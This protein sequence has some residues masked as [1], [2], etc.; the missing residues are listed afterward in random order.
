M[1]SSPRHLEARSATHR[2]PKIAK[3]VSLTRIV[4]KSGASER[5]ILEFLVVCSSKC[6][7]RPTLPCCASSTAL[8]DMRELRLPFASRTG[9]RPRAVLF[10]RPSRVFSPGEVLTRFLT[11]VFP[12][13]VPA[14]VP[15]TRSSMTMP[16]CGGG[17]TP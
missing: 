12:H 10:P 3:W 6:R 8:R 14:H 16:L 11:A 5:L 2:V 4:A 7:L 17:D 13:V 1:P 15:S 9:H